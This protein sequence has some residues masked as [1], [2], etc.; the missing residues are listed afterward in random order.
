VANKCAAIYFVVL[1]LLAADIFVTAV[2][3]RPI[4]LQQWQL[5]PLDP[6]RSVN[7]MAAGKWM[8]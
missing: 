2:S 4:D 1:D 3:L 8:L 6:G 7:I 5:H